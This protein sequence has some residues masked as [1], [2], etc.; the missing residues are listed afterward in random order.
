[1]TFNIINIRITIVCLNGDILRYFYYKINLNSLICSH[2]NIRKMFLQKCKEHLLKIKILDILK[3]IFPQVC[4]FVTFICFGSLRPFFIIEWA[5]YILRQLEILS[6]IKLY[7]V[8]WNSWSLILKV[9][10]LL[11][12]YCYGKRN[13]VLK[14]CE[15]RFPFKIAQFCGF[16]SHFS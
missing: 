2:G 10:L 15:N 16:L 4:T 14:P 7:W 6:S 5:S 13:W 9:T 11:L 8:W 3:Q 1:M 12:L